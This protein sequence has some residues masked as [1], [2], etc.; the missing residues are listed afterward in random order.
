MGLTGLTVAEYFRDDENRDVL[1]F[2]D[3]IFR[4]V[5]LFRGKCS[6]GENTLGSGVPANPGHRPWSLIRADHD[7]QEGE[8]YF[9][10][11]GVCAGR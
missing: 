2:I 9:C 1:L 6:V 11:G 10:T 4:Y 7:N 3:N 8:Y 5:S